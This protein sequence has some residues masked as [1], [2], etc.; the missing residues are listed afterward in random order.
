M[1]NGWKAAVKRARYI[2]EYGCY[3]NDLSNHDIADELA[4]LMDQLAKEN[5]EPEIDW[6]EEIDWEAEDET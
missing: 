3:C 4:F 1:I 5:G 2:M 6:E